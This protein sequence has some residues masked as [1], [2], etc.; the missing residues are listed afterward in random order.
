[1][2]SPS[3]AYALVEDKR[4][5]QFIYRFLVLAG[6]NRNDIRIEVSPAGR[7]SG[8]QWVCKRF[9]QQVE[10]CRK[11]N[12]KAST[13]LFAVIDADELTL[14][15]CISVLDAALAT[16]NQPKLD[17]TKDPVARLIAKWSIETWILY[18]S[19]DGRPNPAVVEDKSYKLEKSPEQWSELIPQ[20]SKTFLAWTRPAAPLPSNLPDSLQ[21]G[22]QEVGYAIPVGR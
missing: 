8:K 18:L 4:H 19:A 22:I 7:G 15:K 21:H 12:A 3:Q 10:V 17:P 1:M 16:A 9:A 5:S 14:S 20:A 6:I 11:R 2:S 13:C